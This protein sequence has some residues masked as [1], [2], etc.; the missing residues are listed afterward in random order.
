VCWL[1]HQHH[2]T[3][4]III[5]IKIIIITKIRWTYAQRLQDLYYAC[6]MFWMRTHTGPLFVVLS[7]VMVPAWKEW[8]LTVVCML[9]IQS[10]YA[11]FFEITA[12]AATP[13]FFGKSCLQCCRQFPKE[14]PTKFLGGFKIVDDWN[15]NYIPRMYFSRRHSDVAL[16]YLYKMTSSWKW[17]FSLPKFPHEC[18]CT[19]VL[20]LVTFI[21][22]LWR[23]T[24]LPLKWRNFLIQ[25]VRGFCHRSVDL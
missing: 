16:L 25:Y 14:S 13:T 12:R 23:S 9:L 8:F 15:P 22:S 18:L 3:T 2:Y 1:H 4:P 19:C 11:I 5:F 20:N 10:F 6:L 21:V 17:S 7:E 24:L